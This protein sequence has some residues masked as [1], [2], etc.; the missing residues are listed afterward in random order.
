MYRNRRTDGVETKRRKARKEWSAGASEE[1][2]KCN[3]LPEPQWGILSH[4]DIGAQRAS[5]RLTRHREI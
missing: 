4:R 2:R 3:E 1:E 5:Q